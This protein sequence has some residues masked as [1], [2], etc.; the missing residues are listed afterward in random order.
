IESGCITT[1]I[2]YRFQFI[3]EPPAFAF[4][5]KSGHP[6][7]RSDQI[8]FIVNSVLKDAVSLKIMLAQHV[9]KTDCPQRLRREFGHCKRSSELVPGETKSVL[10]TPHQS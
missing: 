9:I 2:P 4:K 7:I 5:E 10:V 3:Q 6:R 1:T 8:P